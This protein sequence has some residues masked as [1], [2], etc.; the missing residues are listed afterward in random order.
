M[1]VKRGSRML[2]PLLLL[3]LTACGGTTP[4][5]G[6][7]AGSAVLADCRLAVEGT[8]G[9]VLTQTSGLSCSEIMSLLAFAPAGPGKYLLEGASP[10]I[11]WH[12]QKF[13]AGKGRLLTCQY[14]NHQFSVAEGV[15]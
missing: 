8:P 7:S 2:L 15:D 12:C 10:G 1:R 11:E 13:K 6:V 3:L 9:T 14:R 5:A 4:S